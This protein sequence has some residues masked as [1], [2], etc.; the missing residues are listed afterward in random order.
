MLLANTATAAVVALVVCVLGWG[1]WAVFFKSAKKARYEYFVYDF[2]WGAGLAA[3]VAAFTLGSW[4]TN[5]LTFQDNFL[6]AALRKMAWAVASGLVF[7]LANSLLLAAV[8]VSGMWVAFPVAFGLAW[9]VGAVVDYFVMPGWNAALAFGGAAVVLTSTV[10]AVLAYRWQLADREQ[11]AVEAMKADPNARGQAPKLSATKGAALAIS[12]GVF[13]AI[14]F[15]MIQEAVGGDTGVAP[16]GAAL[17][18]A[19]AIVGS[20]LVYVPFLLNFPV[21]GKPLTVRQ[22]FKVEGKHHIL[23][24][25]A[26]VV[27]MAGF[28]AG[29]IALAAGADARLG[30]VVEYLVP[31]T[32]P[33]LAVVLGVVWGELKNAPVRVTALTV[34]TVVLMLAG[35]GLVAVAPLYGG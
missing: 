26:G 16:Y 13:F 4:D 25:M 5:E 23:G 10:L 31:K 28:L 19:A 8:S 34:A 24:L 14:F 27:W 32:A 1:A 9:A 30:P 2:S 11:R 3:V 20:S 35:L 7:N 17:L 22:Y 18:V 21:R 15:P 6:L 29:L 12:A 33:L